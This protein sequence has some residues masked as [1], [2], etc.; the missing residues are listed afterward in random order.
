MVEY[1]PQPQQQQVPPE[2]LNEKAFS[3]TQLVKQQ[4]SRTHGSSSRIVIVLIQ[5]GAGGRGLGLVA[6]DLG[7]SIVPS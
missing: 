2:V 1:A 4:G 7:H 6:F 3:V 5:G